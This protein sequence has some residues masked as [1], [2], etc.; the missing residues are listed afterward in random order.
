MERG[1]ESV[2]GSRASGENADR[3]EPRFDEFE[4]RWKRGELDVG[5]R[6]TSERGRQA[7]TT[8]KTS[9]D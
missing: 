2:G 3:R 8:C 7:S 5:R 4:E 6:Y 9:E 1:E